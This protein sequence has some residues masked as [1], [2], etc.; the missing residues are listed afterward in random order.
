MSDSLCYGCSNSYMEYG[1]MLCKYEGDERVSL[2]HDDIIDFDRVKEC[3][4]YAEEKEYDYA[5]FRNT[6]HSGEGF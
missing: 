4:L 6:N 1:E 5:E 2:V 3:L